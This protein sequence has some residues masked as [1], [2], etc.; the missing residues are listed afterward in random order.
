M[1]W[2]P[3]TENER[4]VSSIMPELERWFG[5]LSSES[6]TPIAWGYGSAWV[7]SPQF[8]SSGFSRL[9]PLAL[10]NSDY[11]SNSLSPFSLYPWRPKGSFDALEAL[12]PI[13]TT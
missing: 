10:L 7:R 8:F 13:W 3:I 11:F 4:R 2:E 9:V 1:W 12:E 5:N 6:T